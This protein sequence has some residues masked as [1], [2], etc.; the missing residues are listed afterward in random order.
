MPM[1]VGV[2]EMRKEERAFLPVSLKLPFLFSGMDGAKMAQ[3]SAWS[4]C[5][6]C[7]VAKTEFAIPSR[8]S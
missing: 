2:G 7:F 8:E 1:D 5:N 3:P 6:T 4:S